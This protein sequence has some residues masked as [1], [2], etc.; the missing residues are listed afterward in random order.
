VDVIRACSSLH[1]EGERATSQSR[2]GPVPAYSGHFPLHP[3]SSRAHLHAQQR[4]GGGGQDS[5]AAFAPEAD[6][7]PP[8]ARTLPRGSRAAISSEGLYSAGASASEPGAAPPVLPAFKVRGEEEGGWRRAIRQSPPL[9]TSYLSPR[10]PSTS[11]SP[12]PP[13]QFLSDAVALGQGASASLAAR[14]AQALFGVDVTLPA[15][16]AALDPRRVQEA[17]WRERANRETASL[18]AGGAL[19]AAE[20]PG[21]GVDGSMD[22]APTSAG[23]AATGG[24]GARPPSPAPAATSPSRLPVHRRHLSTSPENEGPGYRAPQAS[25][26]SVHVSPSP[27]RARAAAA[28]ALARGV[29]DAQVGLLVGWPGGSLPVPVPVPVASGSGGSPGTARAGGAGAGSTAAV[30]APQVSRALVI[31]GPARSS[32]ANNDTRYSA[33]SSYTFTTAGDATL[34]AR[35]AAAAGASSGWDDE[36]EAEGEAEGEYGTLPEEEDDEGSEY[37]NAA[38][39]PAPPENR[40]DLGDNEEDGQGEDNAVYPPAPAPAPTSSSAGLAAAASAVAA[41]MASKFEQATQAISANVH[42]MESRLAQLEEMK[43]R[44]AAV[45]AARDADEATGGW[46]ERAA[47]RAGSA[48]SDAAADSAPAAAAAY[49]APDTVNLRNIYSFLPTSGLEPSAAAAREGDDGEV[50]AATTDGS[51][52]R[53]GRISDRDL[54]RTAESL[55]RV[56][57]EAASGSASLST[58]FASSAAMPPAGEEDDDDGE[59]DA[60]FRAA[61][62]R[63]RRRQQAQQRPEEAGAAALANAAAASAPYPWERAARAPPASAAAASSASSFDLAG[64]AGRVADFDAFLARNEA[65]IRAPMP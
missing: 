34:A 50:D 61:L 2:R 38:V 55:A 42:K 41:A 59:G 57:A 26:A 58:S 20:A 51:S 21:G 16:A 64:L 11:P 31:P 60:R 36:G 5:D 25:M 30:P 18:R 45:L 35:Q 12:L 32:A 6:V 48:S 65:K 15:L 10:T 24:S 44:A 8:R 4:G 47:L 39:A 46:R 14:R 9:L 19:Y 1:A 54:S 29:S 7:L 40:F 28:A 3:T 23:G 56:R 52:A 43:A 37:G 62:S 63:V 33:A 53:A 49:R 13:L 27:Q 17:G 22:A